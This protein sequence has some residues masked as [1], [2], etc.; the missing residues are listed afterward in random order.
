MKIAG[1]LASLVLAFSGAGSVLAQTGAAGPAELATAV[2]ALSRPA[3]IYVAGK[4]TPEPY[5]AAAGVAF[6]DTG[7]AMTV[8]TPLRIA[9]NAKTFTAATVLRL[10]E[11][12]RIDLDAPIGPLLSASLDD[13]LTADG[14]DTG[15]ITVRHLLSHSGG[16]YDHGGDQRFIEAVMA[17][18]AHYWTREELV[19]L[20]MAYADPQSAPGTA[21][22][23]SDTG[24]IL[25]G[26]IVERIT[27][28]T[29][30]AAVREQLRLDRLGL[31]AT[32]WEIM[33]PAPPGAVRA[34][35]SLGDV[36]AADWHASMDLYGGGGL[37][38]SARDLAVFFAALFEGRVFDKPDTLDMMLWQGPHQRGNH[39]RLGIFVSQANGRT[40][41]WHSGFWGTVALYAPDTGVAVA[42]VT[43]NQDGFRAMRT[44]AESVIGAPPS[45]P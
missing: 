41:Y 9:S 37:V 19:G 43:T 32:W 31:T 23:Y 35:Q 13:L 4:G 18:P 34:P 12:G 15:A 22:R 6:P 16:L 36:S 8:D 20:S 24:Y 29:L 1:F 3:A 17:D 30:G 42:G 14:Y 10:W 7:A 28:Q 26:D 33:E 2:E 39:Y 25:L 5:G 44:L 40:F 27:G 21:F 45:R 11:A 38:M